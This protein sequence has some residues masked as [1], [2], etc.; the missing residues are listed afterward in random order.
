MEYKGYKLHFPI[1]IHIG[2]G[3]LEDSEKTFCADTLFSALCIEAN[4]KSED[5]LEKLVELVRTDK[6]LFSD[7]LPYIGNRLYLPKPFISIAV[8]NQGDSSEKK[9]FKKLEYVP[10]ECLMQY[11][12]GEMNAKSEEDFFKRHFG[13]T[14]SKVSACV[15]ENEETVP[16]RIGLF[17]FREN[18]GLYIIIGYEKECDI[19]FVEELLE[20][21]SFEGIGG[22]RSSG[23]GRFELRPMHIEGDLLHRLQHAGQNRNHMSLSVCLPANEEL[24]TAMQDANYILKKRS[25]FVVSDTYADTNLRKRDLFV[26]QAGSCFRNLF[27]GNIYDVSVQ[28]RHPVYRYAKPMFMGVD[29]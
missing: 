12:N 9:A 25:G 18:A 4:K 23:Y 27:V 14:V 8:D 7:A 6:L 13:H 24:E 19:M 16:Y 26:F 11:L 3:S 22:K 1:G 17:Q 29:I 10:L 5:A 20:G 21:L 15:E 2:D 28:G